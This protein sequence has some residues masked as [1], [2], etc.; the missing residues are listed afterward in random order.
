MRRGVEELCD[1]YNRVGLDAEIFA[2]PRYIRLRH[3]AGLTEAG[4]LS[5]ALRW[6]TTTE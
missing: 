4:R 3:I 6:N 2:G 5:E 1:A